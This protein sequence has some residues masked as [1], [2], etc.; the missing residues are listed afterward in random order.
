MS[1]KIN[2]SDERPVVSPE[3]HRAFRVAYAQLAK[4]ASDEFQ[5]RLLAN[6]EPDMSVRYFTEAE[7]AERST[8]TDFEPNSTGGSLLVETGAKDPAWCYVYAHDE[9]V[10]QRTGTIGSFTAGLNKN[11][12][13]QD[14]YEFYTDG[15]IKKSHYSSSHLAD[16]HWTDDTTEPVGWL[17]PQETEALTI[18]MENPS[19]AL[20]Q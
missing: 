19:V 17:T 8:A 11:A 16:G 1:E 7:V 4:L 3:Q 9:T 13:K 18:M 15:N 10:A 12:T 20:G 5:S 14:I 6:V 2:N